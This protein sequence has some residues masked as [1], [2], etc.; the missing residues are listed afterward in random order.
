MIHSILVL[1][2]LG[3]SLL[4]SLQ[5]ADK[6][7]L[8]VEERLE[9]WKDMARNREIPVKLYIPK[10]AKG[11]FPLIIFSHGL[12]GSR[13]GYA[14][15]GHYWAEHGYVS[16]HVQ[17]AGSDS[18]L[19]TADS[20]NA[21]KALQW[22]VTRPENWINRPEDVSFAIDRML[23]L[24][25][26]DE[27]LKG[28]MDAAKVGVSGH[29]YGGYTAHAVAGLK[30]MVGE[31]MRSFLDTRVKAAIA[32]SPPGKLAARVGPEGCAF[33]VPCLHMMGSN[34]NSQLFGTEAAERRIP[35]DT[36]RSH[37][38][39]LIIVDGADHMVFSG[40][41]WMPG[42]NREMDMRQ[43]EAVCRVTQLFWDAFLK[44]DSV[45]RLK[46]NAS[47]VK[48]LSWGMCAFEQK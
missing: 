13:D 31:G 5:A 18:K 23:E 8:A 22:A 10:H 9:T 40:S 7:S 14:Y 16:V 41:N 17:H 30:V 4:G 48:E 21:K 38:Q 11:P 26:T 35:F 46:W 33:A 43:Q 3:C 42:R 34:D 32:M 12:G 36:T 47:T 37:N 19:V 2:V 39:F 24:N 20:G 15:L 1:L 44:G 6:T 29:S 27:Q 25:K 45:A 28:R